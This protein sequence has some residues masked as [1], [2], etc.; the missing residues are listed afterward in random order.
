VLRRALEQVEQE[1]QKE[2]DHDPE[3]EISKIVQGPSFHAGPSQNQATISA[4]AYSYLIDRP[5]LP[6][7]QPA[8][9]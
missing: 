9:R 1:H 5:F 4:D 2:R 6:Y 3:R 8:K 7:C